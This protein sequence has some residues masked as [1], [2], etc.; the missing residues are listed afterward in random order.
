[1][2]HY[3]TRYHDAA[4]Q[5]CHL[6]LTS[7]IDVKKNRMAAASG[8]TTD[9][10]YYVTFNGL[11]NNRLETEVQNSF[12]AKKYHHPFLC[13]VCLHRA[14]SKLPNPE[15]PKEPRVLSFKPF[16]QEK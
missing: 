15:E 9:N 2:L 6:F 10:S 14:I 16:G 7:A 13:W 12:C 5:S 3:F 8:D 4:L 11:Q 1:M